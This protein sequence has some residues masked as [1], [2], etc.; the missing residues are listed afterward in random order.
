MNESHTRTTMREF[1]LELPLPPLALSPNK[2]GSHWGVRAWATRLYREACGYA[3]LSQIGRRRAKGPITV[4]LDFYLAKSA[5][6]PD[7]LYRPR[8]RD[9]ALAAC[10]ACLDSLKD[11]GL[12]KS[13]SKRHL[14]IG[15]IDLHTTK[16]EH[17]GKTGLV[18]TIRETNGDG[19]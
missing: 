13:D 12:I 19:K 15:R 2:K 17:G 7:T 4:D 3:A 6:V 18:M 9:N 11:T 5:I 10:K 14:I 16:K 8:D 1:K